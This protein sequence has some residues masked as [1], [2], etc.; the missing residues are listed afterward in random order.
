MKSVSTEPSWDHSFM[1]HMSHPAVTTVKG[2][3]LSSCLVPVAWNSHHHWAF[4]TF[5]FQLKDSSSVCHACVSLKINSV[6]WGQYIKDCLVGPRLDLKRK[7][8]YVSCKTSHVESPEPGPP[9]SLSLTRKALGR[10]LKQADCVSFLHF[11]RATTSQR[12]LRVH[13]G[14]PLWQVC[15]SPALFKFSLDCPI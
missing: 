5:F 6:W 4:E 15:A 7:S 9:H 13:H 8:N 10:W 11:G 3:E 2:E 12:T 14:S 1:S